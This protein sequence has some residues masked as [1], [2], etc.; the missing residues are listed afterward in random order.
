MYSRVK[1]EPESRIIIPENYDGTAF[2]QSVEDGAKPQGER[3]I[4]VLG[5]CSADAKMSPGEMSK[6]DEVFDGDYEKSEPAAESFFEKIPFGGQLSRWF[7]AL[8]ARGILPKK[9]GTEEIL[10][11]ATALFLFFS[12]S[13]DKECAIMLGLL[14][15]V[16][17]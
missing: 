13:G 9:F 15:L 12:K 4:K 11:I 7:G 10:I 14:L 2:I 1:G 6:S 17:N 5:E 3:K 16:A 8:P